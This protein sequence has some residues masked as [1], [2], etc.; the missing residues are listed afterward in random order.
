MAPTNGLMKSTLI[1]RLGAA[2]PAGGGGIIER[3]L[4]AENGF[5]PVRL[6]HALQFRGEMDGVERA[7]GLFQCAL[8]KRDALKITGLRFVTPSKSKM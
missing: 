2:M 6:D 3:F 7:F 5:H 4:G 1:E 8:K